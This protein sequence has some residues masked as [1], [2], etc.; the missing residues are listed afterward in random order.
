MTKQEFDLLETGDFLYITNGRWKGHSFTFLGRKTDK[1]VL[2]GREAIHYKHL[3]IVRT[4]GGC[5]KWN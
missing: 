1:C 3:T 5:L 2:C 4:K